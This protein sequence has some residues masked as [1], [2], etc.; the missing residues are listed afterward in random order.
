MT[1]ALT[2]S[3]GLLVGAGVYLLLGKR[4]FP[5]ILA[6][7]L[8]SHGVH[9]VMVASGRGE[10]PPILTGAEG[11]ASVADPIPQALVLTAIVISM[12]VTLYLLAVLVSS[13]RLQPDGEVP[14]PRSDDA[15]RDPEAV[16]AELEGKGGSR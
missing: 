11:T 6:F 14:Q 9:L 13:G 7:S 10:A 8:L 15:S 4:L 16:R 1:L 3:V 2:L 12:T 5:A